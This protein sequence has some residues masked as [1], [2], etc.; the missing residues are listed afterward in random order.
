M[1]EVLPNDRRFKTVPLAALDAA[2]PFADDSSA[3]D[4][5][6]LMSPNKV[7]SNVETGA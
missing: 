1:K 2:T 4:L 6:K 5:S 3:G 7:P